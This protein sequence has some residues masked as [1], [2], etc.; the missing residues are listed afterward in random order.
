MQQQDEASEARSTDGGH[1]EHHCQQNVPVNP[2]RGEHRVTTAVASATIPSQPVGLVIDSQQ[3]QQGTAEASAHDRTNCTERSP[4]N[5]VKTGGEDD[6]ERHRQSTS[7]GTETFSA[8]LFGDRHSPISLPFD[9]ELFL[10]DHLND[11]A[12]SAT[13]PALARSGIDQLRT[14][15]TPP[16]LDSHWT[17]LDLQLQPQPQLDEPGGREPSAGFSTTEPPDPLWWEAYM[18]HHSASV[19]GEPHS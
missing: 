9:G 2:R 6:K 7:F 12:A 16:E 3:E 13:S 11:A 14:R 8:P 18:C 19:L 1:P 5:D 17:N 4:E 15:S 10:V